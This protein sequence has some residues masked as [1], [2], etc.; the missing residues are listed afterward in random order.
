MV[1]TQK[2]EESVK[3][4]PANGQMIVEDEHQMKSEIVRAVIPSLG[5][6]S[7]TITD[8]NDAC[9]RAVFAYLEQ[10][11]LYSVASASVRFRKVAKEFVKRVAIQNNVLFYVV[12]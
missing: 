10:G 5:S 12:R 6:S 7:T 2:A 11:D 9:F 1:D 4:P 3:S 8:L